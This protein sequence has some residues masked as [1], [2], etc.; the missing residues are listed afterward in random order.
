M[1]GRSSHLAKTEAG[2]LATFLDGALNVPKKNVPSDERM[3]V[4]AAREK[5]DSIMK[6]AFSMEVTLQL[7]GAHV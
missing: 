2:A 7:I 6:R 1:K 5:F 3:V 4:N